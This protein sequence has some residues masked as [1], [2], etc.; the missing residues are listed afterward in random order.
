VTSLQQFRRELDVFIEQAVSEQGQLRI[1]TAFA[2]E[3]IERFKADWREKS[4]GKAAVDVA[5]DGNIEAPLSS[6]RLNSVILA[7]ARTLGVAV[8]RALELYDTFVKIKTGDYKS[9]LVIYADS[10]KIGRQSIPKI[11][12]GTEILISNVSPFARKAEFREFN[13]KNTSGFSD[14]LFESLAVI[15]SREAG[16]LAE[17][18]FDYFDFGGGRLPSL[19]LN[20]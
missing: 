3:E 7:R 17:V 6:A 12:P 10:A 20:Q 16:D 4:G 9:D 19:I 14:G 15:M 2:E 1:F 5:V 18:R 13:D 11:R 8:E